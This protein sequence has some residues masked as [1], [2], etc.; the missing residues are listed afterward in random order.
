M[1]FHKH[2]EVTALGGALEWGSHVACAA[3]FMSS[4]VYLSGDVKRVTA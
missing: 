2:G 4:S 3:G 1:R